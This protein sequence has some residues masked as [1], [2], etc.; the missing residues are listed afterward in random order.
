M[1]AM[2]RREIRLRADIPRFAFAP[3]RKDDMAGSVQVIV[4]NRVVAERELVYDGGAA[5]AYP[6]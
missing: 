1:P 2:A 6:V 3:V 5:L 4:N